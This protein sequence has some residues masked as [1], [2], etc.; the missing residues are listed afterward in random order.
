MLTIDEVRN[1]FVV[2]C[3]K[4]LVQKSVKNNNPLT[5]E[6]RSGEGVKACRQDATAGS[7]AY[8]YVRPDGYYQN[9]PAGIILF[10]TGKGFK[11][12]PIND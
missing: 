5:I 4:F 2:L 6:V 12:H 10:S 1:L 11:S 8:Y 7:T 3:E 9:K